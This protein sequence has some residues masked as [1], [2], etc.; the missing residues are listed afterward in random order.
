MHSSKYIIQNNDLL[1]QRHDAK[2]E[3]GRHGKENEIQ[4]NADMHYTSL[5]IHCCIFKSLKP[6]GSFVPS[7]ELDPCY[8]VVMIMYLSHYEVSSGM[9]CVSQSFVTRSALSL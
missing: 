1:P 7:R 3:R 5:K 6:K 2:V 9:V 4:A 8:K